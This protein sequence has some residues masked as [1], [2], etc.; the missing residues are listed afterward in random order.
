MA[1]DIKEYVQ[2]CNVGCA[3]AEAHT[4]IPP[5]GTKKAPKKV[6]EEFSADFKG[7]IGGKYYIHTI[8]DNYSQWP[9][10]AIVD[11]TSF[12]KLK[13][14]VVRTFNFLGIPRNFVTDNGPPYQSQQWK[15][16]AKEYGFSHRPVTPLHP[17]AN[18]QI[19]CFN[20]VLVKTIH[21]AIAEGKD[22]KVEVKR[23]VLNYR[24]TTHYTTGVAPSELVL[25]GLIRTKM[26][27]MLRQ[28]NTKAHK[29]ARKNDAEAKRKTK[30]R[31]DKRK[32]A[33]ESTIKTG[34]RVLLAQKKS[35][36]NPPF[37]PRP[38][39]VLANKHNIIEVERDGKMKKRHASKVKKLWPR[40]EHLRK[41]KKEEEREGEGEREGRD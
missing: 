19:E 18:G 12:E 10:V 14:H 2:S 1:K 20:R 15:N 21:A 34:D 30:E 38:Y 29:M 5:A 41:K 26:P 17:E 3:A 4:S 32:R 6:A 9:E 16:L 37:D 27:M 24:N 13:P 39:E 11:S 8:M 7:P 22:P 25:G 33:T 31:L 23:R 40:P 28:K 36:T 35:T